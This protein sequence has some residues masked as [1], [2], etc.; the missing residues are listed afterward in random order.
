V[1]QTKQFAKPGGKLHEDVKDVM[2]ATGML[3]KVPKLVGV[4]R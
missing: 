1:I 2:A 4:A 3:E